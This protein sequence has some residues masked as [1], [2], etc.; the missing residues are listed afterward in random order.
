MIQV[1][2]QTNI[3][4]EEYSQVTAVNREELFNLLSNI[5]KNM[6]LEEFVNNLVTKYDAAISYIDLVMDK[7]EGQKI[8]LLFNPHRLDTVAK[9]SRYSIYKGLAEDYFVKGLARATLFK[10]GKVSELL[11]QAIQL[12]INS[13]QYINEFPPHI[14]RDLCKKYK[15]N[16]GSKVLDPCAGWGGRMIGASV[17]VDNY[18]GYEPSVRTYNGL[19]ELIKFIQSFRK[20]FKGEIYNQPY[21]DSITTELF[22]FAITSPPYYDTE[23]YSDEET[24]SINRY[25]TFGRWVEYFYLPLIKLTLNRLKSNSYFILNIGSR[26]YPLNKILLDNFKEYEIVK[27]GNLLSGTA[28]LDKSGE[29]EMFYQIKTN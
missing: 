22:D 24:N 16:R 9:Q 5:L 11:Y 23:R 29:G 7:N 15:L 4:G 14:M 10:K 26:K 17:I 28:G 6:S 19:L 13:I 18:T 8:S 1:D 27:I 3:F 21:E 12:G 25:F 20:E 2:N